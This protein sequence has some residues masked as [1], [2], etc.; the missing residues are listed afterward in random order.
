MSAA[1]VQV[2][3]LKMHFPIYAGLFRRQVGSL[4]AVDGV[5]FDIMAG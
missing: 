1:L 2:R 4:K 3:D 5:S